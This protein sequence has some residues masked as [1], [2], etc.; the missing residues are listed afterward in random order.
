MRIGIRRGQRGHGAVSVDAVV[1]LR[2][3]RPPA[4]ENIEGRRGGGAIHVRRIGLADL[5]TRPPGPPQSDPDLLHHLVQPA[6]VQP[7]PPTHLPDHVPEPRDR[8]LE[9]K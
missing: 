8:R 2:L 6:L 5:L 1:A 7:V 9:G 4:P 3:A